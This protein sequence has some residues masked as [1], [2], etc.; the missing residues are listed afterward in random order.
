MFQGANRVQINDGVFTDINGDQFNISIRYIDLGALNHATAQFANIDQHQKVIEVLL[1]RLKDTLLEVDKQRSQDLRP[2]S[3]TEVEKVNRC[4]A[5]LCCAILL[6][7]DISPL[8]SA[9]ER[10]DRVVTTVATMDMAPR[11]Y[12]SEKIESQLKDA[13][14]AIALATREIDVRLLYMDS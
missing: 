6:E 3:E 13:E 14:D 2:L 9:F 12:H 4:D 10:V 11:L 1:N 7:V 5:N 8:N